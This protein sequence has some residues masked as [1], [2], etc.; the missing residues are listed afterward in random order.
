MTKAPRC[1]QRECTHYLG[2]LQPDNTELTETP[3]C[4]AFPQG[5]PADIAWGN[6]LHATPTPDQTNTVVYE[7][8]PNKAQLQAQAYL[9]AQAATEEP[10]D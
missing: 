8:G 4:V 5:I 6:N 9:A 2:I 7:K 10:N 1:H 3:Y